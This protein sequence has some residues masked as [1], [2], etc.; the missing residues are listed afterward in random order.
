VKP[1]L[2]ELVAEHTDG[3]EKEALLGIAARAGGALLKGVGWL[4]AKAIKNPL[5]TMGAAA[6]ASDLSAGTK[7]F[8]NMA[9]KNPSNPFT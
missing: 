9:N 5:T 4:G 6:T 8:A 1:N 7:R 3:I 2:F